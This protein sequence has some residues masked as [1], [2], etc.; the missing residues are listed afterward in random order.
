MDWCNF[1][2]PSGF[3]QPLEFLWSYIRP[4]WMAD[5][6]G[7]WGFYPFSRGA[8]IGTNGSDKTTIRKAFDF[9]L[10]APAPII[11][12]IEKHWPTGAG[13]GTVTKEMRL[14]WA[15]SAGRAIQL[16]DAVRAERPSPEIPI[17]AYVSGSFDRRANQAFIGAYIDGYAKL[18]IN[19]IDF[20][21]IDIY[22][23]PNDVTAKNYESRIR[24]VVQ[25]YKK[26]NKPIVVIIKPSADGASS[27]MA[28]FMRSAKR[29]CEFEKV[30]ALAFW[31][32]LGLPW[33]NEIA[34][35]YGGI[36]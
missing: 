1:Q 29:A 35:A 26:L 24:S 34:L 11:I 36:R 33:S 21:V 28:G 23:N 32:E 12:D 4:I 9:A 3:R 5:H 19:K 2:A 8:D 17:G 25:S 27:D 22:A 18:F 6:G 20:L 14:S 30:K 7:Q 31:D 13:F 10:N 16:I 15:I